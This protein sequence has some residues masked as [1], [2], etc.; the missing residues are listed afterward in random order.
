MFLCSAGRP[1][2]DEIV[3]LSPLIH[4]LHLRTF[5]HADESGITVSDIIIL[6]VTV[7]SFGDVMMIGCGIRGVHHGSVA[8]IHSDVGF[9]PEVVVV[10][11]SWWKPSRDHGSW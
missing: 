2:T 5:L 1:F 10:C 11:P 6:P 8:G 3:D 7:M 4:L 9:H